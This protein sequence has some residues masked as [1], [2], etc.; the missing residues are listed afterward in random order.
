MAGNMFEITLPITEG[1][2]LNRFVIGVRYGALLFGCPSG[3]IYSMWLQV[4]IEITV[5]S[6]KT[7]PNIVVSWL[8]TP[9]SLLDIY[10][11]YGVMDCLNFQ[12]LLF[13][14]EE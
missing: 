12:L 8:M 2:M 3:P 6:S 4:N 7:G 5:L 10:Q 14:S 1:Q 11:C 13:A 9:C